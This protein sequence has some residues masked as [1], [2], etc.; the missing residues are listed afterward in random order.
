MTVTVHPATVQY[1]EGLL[2]ELASLT[3]QLALLPPEAILAA[4]VIRISTEERMSGDDALEE[5]LDTLCEFSAAAFN[6]KAANHPP[7]HALGADVPSGDA[8]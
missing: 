3:R 7:A 8:A 6:L 5:I 2:V 4:E 1:T